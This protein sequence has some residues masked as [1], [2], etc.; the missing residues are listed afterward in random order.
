MLKAQKTLPL[1]KF[2][3]KGKH[4]YLNLAFTDIATQP[5]TTLKWLNFQRLGSENQ[6]CSEKLF[7]NALIR[8]QGMSDRRCLKKWN[9]YFQNKQES[10]NA[11]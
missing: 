11:S 1:I 6:N 9:I 10:R 5:A 4:S 8:F 3:F 2:I 7:A